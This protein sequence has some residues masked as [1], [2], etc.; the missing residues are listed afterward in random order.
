LNPRKPRV[1]FIK[2][3]REGVRGDIGRRIRNPR[4]RSEPGLS[5]PVSSGGRPIRDLRIGFKIPEV[6]LNASDPHPTVR[7]ITREGVSSYSNRSRSTKDQRPAAISPNSPDA[8]RKRRPLTA[9][10]PP[11]FLI[12]ASTS[13]TT[14]FN[15]PHAQLTI[16]RT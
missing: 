14:R 1:S 5:E 9:A 12:P 11:E 2:H 15:P 3:T 8:R 4:P 13:A 16:P 6:A 10:R 7:I